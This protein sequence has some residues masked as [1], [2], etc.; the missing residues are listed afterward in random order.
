M[1]AIKNAIK[2]IYRYKSKYIMFG[3]LYFFVI[4]AASVCLN[5]FAQMGEVTE[6]IIKEYASVAKFEGRSADVFGNLPPRLTKGEFLGFGNMEHIEDIKFLRYNFIFDDIHVKENFS[7]LERELVIGGENI[8]WDHAI[9]PLIVSGYDMAL[10]HLAAEEFNLESGRMFEGD[11]ECVM[12]KNRLVA[13]TG[14]WDEDLVGVVEC[15]NWNDME[16]GDMIVIQNDDGI[17]KEFTVVG[18]L[19]QNPRDDENTHRRM[20][21]TTLESAEHFDVI[22]SESD[23][24]FRFHIPDYDK[25]ASGGGESIFPGY[26]ALIY[27]NSPENYSELR[28]KMAER[29]I[30]IGPLFENYHALIN[31][32]QNQQTWSAVFMIITGLIL[33]CVTVITTVILLHGRRYEMAVLRSVGMKKSRLVAGYLVEN[34]AFILG[35]TL[36]AL[37]AAQIVVP[38]FTGGVFAG[39]QKFVST[40]MMEKL[41]GGAD[42]ELL[43]RNAGF[44]FAGASA[45]AG[46]SLVLACVSIVRF[47]PLKIFGKQY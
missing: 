9:V 23:M 43:L 28:A 22:A 15:R 10:L 33:V 38:M 26:D 5:I 34:L 25:S 40:E 42:L 14:R 29:G 3:V 13:N 47:Q 35:I 1:F 20:I 27:I 16:L 19:E 45:A 39:M 24:A 8:A 30:L 11:D 2:N 12:A 37:M 36:A 44:V 6:N 31:L 4:S 17:Y 41:A 21:Y 32:T 7:G 46:L 18:I